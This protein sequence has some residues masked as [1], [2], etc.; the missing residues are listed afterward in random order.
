MGGYLTFL[1]GPYMRKIRKIG[2]R[3]LLS[4]TDVPRA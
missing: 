3:T 2:Y 4:L 1:L